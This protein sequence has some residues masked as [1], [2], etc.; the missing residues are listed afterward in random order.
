MAVMELVII[1]NYTRIYAAIIN[2][3]TKMMFILVHEF[4]HS[5][6]NPLTEKYSFIE[7][8]DPIF[9][10]IWDKMKELG[11]GSN[12]SILNDHIVRAVT[13]RYL[14]LQRDDISYYNKQL[15]TD[16]EWGFAYIENIMTS[17]EFYERNRNYYRNIDEFYPSLIQ[18][19][20][21]KKHKLK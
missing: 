6:I 2:Q 14:F 18:N 20:V 11:Y 13:L 21:G 10:N 9:K 16:E 1:K 3:K 12:K 4:S 19:L 8:D 7:E 17:L 5:F 15:K